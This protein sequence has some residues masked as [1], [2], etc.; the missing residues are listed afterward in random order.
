MKRIALLL[1]N[2]FDDKELIYPYFR[3]QEA[4]YQVDLVGT[5]PDTI[6]KSKHGMPMKS[7]LGAEEAK[8]DDYE[9]LVIPGGFSPDYMRRSQATIDFV[10]TLN[11]QKKPIAA[12]CHAPWVLISSCDLQGARLTGFPSLQVDIENA[13]ATY[14]DEAVVV[15]GNLITSRTPKDLPA[16]LKA[17][18]EALDT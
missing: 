8:S 17:I 2:Q 1:E 4:G 13:G 16:F 6:Y 18:L 11:D 9:A 10:R 12:I 7:D 14:M 3:L 15:D 5:K